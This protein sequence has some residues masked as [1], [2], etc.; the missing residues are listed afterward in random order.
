MESKKERQKKILSVTKRL[1]I[2][3]GITLILTV[4]LFI[5][6]F[7]FESRFYTSWLSFECGIIGGFVSIQQRLKTIDNDELNLLSESWASILLVPIYGGIFALV[8][9]V[10][11]LSGLLEGHL[12]PYFDLPEFHEPTNTDDIIK[13]LRETYP[14]TASDFAKLIFWSFVAGF[15]ERFVPQVIHKV[16]QTGNQE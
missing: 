14:A 6:T 11:F 12:F 3:A 2:F 1:L 4:L 7:I 10:I 16:G 8:L 5:P 13:L 15:S 9:Y